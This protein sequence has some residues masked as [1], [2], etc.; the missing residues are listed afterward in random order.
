[1]VNRRHERLGIRYLRV[2]TAL[3][4]VAGVAVVLVLIAWQFFPASPFRTTVLL[5]GDPMVVAS[6]DGERKRVSLI[7]IPASVTITGITGVGEYS[8]ESLWRL[9]ELDAKNKNLLV[10]SLSDVLAVPIPWYIGEAPL[11]ALFR[12][13]TI[14]KILSRQYRSNLP[15]RV[16]LPILVATRMLRSDAFSTLTLAHSP[17]IVQ[18]ERADGTTV[19]FLDINRLDAIFGTL[20][21]EEAVRAESLRVMIYNTT[22]TPTLGRRMERRISRAGA[23]VVGVMNDTPAVERCVVFVTKEKLQS[24]TAVFLKQFFHCETKE[25]GSIRSDIEVR[26]GRDFE[27]LFRS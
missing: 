25:G 5:A 4:A 2:F 8:L 15:I 22:Q 16:L 20:L 7:E 1:M 6:W 14:W 9:G 11:S 17:A 24:K 12:P 19:D 3:A 26:V 13:E 18:K 10:D 27:R 23:L 21:E